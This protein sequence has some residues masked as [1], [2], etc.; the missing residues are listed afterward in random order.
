VHDKLQQ[1]VIETVTEA[2]Q[3]KTLYD[4]YQAVRESD[5]WSKLEL[6]QQRIIELSLRS[7]TLSGVGLEGEEKDKF[8]KLKL[9]AAELVSGWRLQQL[10]SPLEADFG[11]VLG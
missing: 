10:Q 7:A 9:R 8:N 6:A 4:A 5:D 3:S 11:C 2:S 1:L